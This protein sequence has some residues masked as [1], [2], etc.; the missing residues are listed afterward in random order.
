VTHKGQAVEGATISF[1]GQG[2][3]R[4]ASAVSAS[5]GTYK[6]MTLDQEG[7]MPGEYVVT[8]T[9]TEMPAD[10][11]AVI[12][13]EEAEKANAKPLAQPKELL[14]AKYGDP[15]KT[16]LKFQVKEGPNTIDLELTD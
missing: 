2:N 5:D 7:A 15:L 1:I 11:T 3:A 14:P 13:M 16:T 9:K 8:V 12:S 10:A 6:L 4:S